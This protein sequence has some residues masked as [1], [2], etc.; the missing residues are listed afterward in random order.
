MPS[1]AGAGAEL[2][3]GP[4]NSQALDPSK[5]SRM[6]SREKRK[7]RRNPSATSEGPLEHRRSHQR[8]PP[9]KKQRKTGPGDDILQPP[10]AVKH[11]LLS[12]YYPTTPTLRQYVLDSLPASSRL[13]RRKIAAVGIAEEGDQHGLRE[14]LATLLDTTLVGIHVRRKE[15]VKAQSESRLQQWIDYSQRDDSHVTLSG[16][17]ASAIHFQSEVGFTQGFRGRKSCIGPWNGSIEANEYWQIV[18]FVIWLLFSREKNPS[19]RPHHL[20][21]DGFR[22]NVG[23]RQHGVPSSIQGLFS[24]YFNE[25]VAAIKQSPWPQL[26]QLLGKSGESIMINLLLDC[27]IFLHVEAGQ[28]N[29]YQLSGKICSRGNLVNPIS[30][31][32]FRNPDFRVRAVVLSS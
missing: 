17:D 23:P 30:K 6:S 19:N 16:G 4:A 3:E 2:R 22:K 18:D 11:A 12:Q 28:G 14:Q 15:F 9:P 27:S 26:L 7:R 10:D 25:R 21:C 5:A 8:P 24:L 1:V 32:S 20:L 31:I 13:R 29:Y